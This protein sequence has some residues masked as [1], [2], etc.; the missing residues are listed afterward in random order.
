M[1]VVVGDHAHA[2][3]DRAAALAVRL[4]GTQA[5]VHEEGDLRILREVAAPAALAQ[6]VKPDCAVVVRV[7]ERRDVRL[8][9]A[10]GSREA[11]VLLLRQELLELILGHAELLAADLHRRSAGCVH[12]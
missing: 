5:V 12:T 3:E 8:G 10:V 2:V 11:A 4:A 1:R 6:R 9:D 7:A